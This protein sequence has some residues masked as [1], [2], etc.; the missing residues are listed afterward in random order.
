MFATCRSPASAS[1]LSALLASLGQPAAVAL[2]VTEEASIQ[3][4]YGAVREAAGRVD[5]LINNAGEG[6]DGDS[7]RWARAVHRR[8]RSCDIPSV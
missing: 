5:L 7:P 6:S 1:Q 2:D 4:A 8:G 3:A